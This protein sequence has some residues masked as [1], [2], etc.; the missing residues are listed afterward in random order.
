MHASSWVCSSRSGHMQE[1]S[2]DF[3]IPP[4]ADDARLHSSPTYVHCKAGKSRSVTVV[5]GYLIHA[6]AW[7]LKTSYAYVAERRK[8]ISP[9]IGFVAELMQFEEGE[10]GLKGSSGI[11]TDSNVDKGAN[12][13]DR[14]NSQS[15]RNKYGRESL[16]PTWGPATDG[17][18][19]TSPVRGPDEPVDD[20]GVATP[21]QAAANRSTPQDFKQGIPDL[22]DQRGMNK[23][24]RKNGQ[25]VQFRR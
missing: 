14:D 10:L 12:E 3:T 21:R 4:L 8:G 24:V 11:S 23:E 1:L 19:V 18:F 5:L 22:A 7:T 25:Y 9:N 16:P 20:D 15:R 17:T 6:N 13:S 2:T